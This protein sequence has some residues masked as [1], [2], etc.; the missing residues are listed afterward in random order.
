M[1]KPRQS[2]VGLPND[3]PLILTAT[4]WL[5]RLRDEDVDPQVI[6]DWECWLA[7]SAHHRRAFVQVQT[8]WEAMGQ[9]EALPWPTDAEVFNDRYAAE[10]SVAA[11]RT[12]AGHTRDRPARIAHRLKIGIAGR[13]LAAA[14][15]CILIALIAGVARQAANRP[16]PA[17]LAPDTAL[18]TVTAEHKS[19]SLPDGSTVFLGGATRVTVVLT[20]ER[21]SLRLDRGEAFFEVAHDTARPFTVRAGSAEVTA[22][23]TAF[24]VR[25]SADGVLVAVTHGAVKLD[26][27][28]LPEL[29]GGA[30]ARQAQLHAGQAAE[31]S[32]AGW[33]SPIATNVPAMTA[34]REGRLQYSSEPLRVVVAELTRYSR[35]PVEVADPGVG[36]VRVTATVF[37]GDVHGWLEGLEQAL[38]VKV[39]FGKD[40]IVISKREAADR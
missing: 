9:N 3:D 4:E 32:Q 7:T 26:T 31:L 20:P 12:A 29:T 34:W 22:V 21:R 35:V 10:E 37:E 2:S 19:F 40:R 11:W 36:D 14:A 15:A 13:P 1:T 25:R 33:S 6:A 16:P 28:D 27:L 39:D 17:T 8:V 5:I 24:D 30:G 23:G 38:P 18:E